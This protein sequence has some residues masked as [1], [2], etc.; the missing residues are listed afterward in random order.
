MIAN[1]YAKRYCIK[2]D[3]CKSENGGGGGGFKWPNIDNVICEQS[4]T[5]IA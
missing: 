3:Y 2:Y 1:Y 4:F 5:A